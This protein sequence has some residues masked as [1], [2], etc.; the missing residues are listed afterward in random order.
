MLKYSIPIFAILLGLGGVMMEQNLV[1]IKTPSMH[2]GGTACEED[3]ILLKVYETMAYYCKK[4]M[5]TYCKLQMYTEINST[6]HVLSCYIL[7]ELKDCFHVTQCSLV[8]LLTIVAMYF[9]I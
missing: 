1:V 4:Q 6:D 5:Y 8:S 7:S 2:K 3:S 9:I